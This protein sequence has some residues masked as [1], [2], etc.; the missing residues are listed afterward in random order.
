V[1]DDLRVAA[2]T[3][4]FTRV[5]GRATSATLERGAP[6]QRVLEVGALA[7]REVVDDGDA[8]AR[9]ISASTRLEAMKLAPPVTTVSMC[10]G[11]LDGVGTFAHRAS[12]PG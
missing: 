12:P 9:A 5:R 8:V 11:R 10:R 7:R 4:S 3:I 1:K 2:A 6:G